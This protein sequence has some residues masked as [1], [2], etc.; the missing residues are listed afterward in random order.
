[1]AAVLVAFGAMNRYRNV[2]AVAKHEK[3][4]GILRRT[5]MAEVLI[6]SGVF[7]ATGVLSELPPA[8]VQAATG[9][10]ATKPL[11]VTGHDFAQSVNVRMTV[12]PGT[13]GPNRFDA[14]ITDFDTGK[15]VDATSVV[16]NLSLPGNPSVGNPQ[17]ALKETGG[18]TWTGQGTVLSIFGKWQV[19]M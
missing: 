7:A 5:V 11:V 18:G 14:R 4:P 2:P 16:L 8:N 13:V 17:L 12:T 6:A 19:Q 9:T 3:P 10:E 1:I 15:P